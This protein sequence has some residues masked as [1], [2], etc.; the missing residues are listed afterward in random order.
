MTAHASQTVTDGDRSRSSVQSQSADPVLIYDGLCGFCDWAVQFILARDPGGRMRFAPIQGAFAREVL[1]R[2]PAQAAIDSVVL[3]TAGDG[4][5]PERLSIRS[6]AA[7]EV[8]RYLGG[9]W[10]VALVMRLLP[11]GARDWAYDAFARNRYRWFGR[12]GSCPIP[13]AE[14][15]ERFLA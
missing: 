10:R 6:D 13:S 3:V 2:H 1:A 5:G 7:L 9:A 4:R 8:V 15:R 12:Y 11:R 14:V